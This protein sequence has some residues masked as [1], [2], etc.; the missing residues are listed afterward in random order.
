MCQVLV[1]VISRDITDQKRIEQQL[2]HAEKLA[3]LGALSAGVAH[4]INNPIAIIL[5]FSEL[6]LAKVSRGLQRI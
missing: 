2:F 6:L 5:G 1:L 4:E 3:S